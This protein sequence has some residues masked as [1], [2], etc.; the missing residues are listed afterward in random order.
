MLVSN[1]QDTK[2]VSNSYAS[3]FQNQVNLSRYMTR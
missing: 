2:I 3:G 1:R